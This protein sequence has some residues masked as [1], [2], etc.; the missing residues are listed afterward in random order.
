M[1][2][3][4]PF[5]RR[6]LLQFVG[7]GMLGS[8]VP[9]MGRAAE[10]VR[11]VVAGDSQGMKDGMLSASAKMIAYAIRE[12]MT[13]S[14]EVTRHYLER[15][16]STNSLLDAVVL[17]TAEQA[18]EQA[19]RADAALAKRGATG[20][21]HGVPMTLKD[22]IDT[23]GVVT[24]Y[25][26]A[27][28][29]AA[30][31][32]EDATVVRRLK[33][34]GAVLIGKTNTPELTLSFETDNDVFGRTMN[35]FVPER[36]PGGSSGGA[37]A[38]VSAGLSAF[39]I[40]SDTGGSIRVP[41]HCC[42]TVGLKPTQGR[43]PRTGHAISYGGLHDG[44]TTLGPI[45]RSVDDLELILRVI[46]GPDGRDPFVAAAPLRDS[47]EVDIA[48]LRVAWHSDNGIYT[49]TDEIRS[50]VEAA[51]LSLGEA[52]A[53]LTE[54]VPPPI[55]DTN[56]ALLRLFVWNDDGGAWIRRLLDAAGTG[57]PSP[58]IAVQINPDLRVAGDVIVERIEARDRF[59]AAMVAFMADYDVLVTPVTGF[60]APPYGQAEDDAL[61]PGYSY[62]QVYNLS[63]LPA[64]VVRCGTS[65]EGLPIGVQIAAPP[66]R[67]DLAL[68]VA[69]H[70]EAE[71]GGWQ[72]PPLRS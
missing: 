1:A 2:G 25:G 58:A 16:E 9:A 24:T 57:T 44:L 62:T 30:V 64:A 60:P 36:S 52:G 33:A 10:D 32:T 66:W 40:G 65:P 70:L 42:G 28:R 43:V 14:T 49:P 72:A 59:R 17:V 12:G 46:A 13:T 4:R 34:A 50:V 48:G 69:R 51:A 5:T 27:G 47:R 22:S 7:A 68:A 23:A 29:R 3:D 8:A 54:I 6:E 19:A 56:E 55:P 45:A 20:P 53:A 38:A 41:S 31:P 61:F 11:K 26:T 71:F 21:L 67:E 35:P 39:D 15:I 18:L 37:A 63:G